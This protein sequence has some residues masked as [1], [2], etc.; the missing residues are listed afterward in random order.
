M[1]NYR[2]ERSKGQVM[3]NG[4]MTKILV[5]DDSRLHRIMLTDVLTRGGYEIAEAGDGLEALA[6]VASESPD[7]II[8]DRV[9]P[10]MDGSEVC[11][12]LKAD[13]FTRH[14]PALML[15]ASETTSEKVEGLK[16]GADAYLTKPFHPE[17][18]LATVEALLRRGGWGDSTDGW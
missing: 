7:L 1:Y 4:S 6:K 16:L 12:R 5:V 9:M 2:R 14:I 11:R 18:L 15:T 17:E 8:L 3:G 10:K 13:A